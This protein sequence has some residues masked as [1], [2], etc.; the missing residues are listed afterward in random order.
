MIRGFRVHEGRQVA[1][2]GVPAMVDG[3]WRV[4]L[5]CAAVGFAAFAHP[6]SAGSITAS[7]TAD[8]FT[9][10]QG[11]SATLKLTLTDTPLTGGSYTGY[12]YIT[13]YGGTLNP[14]GGQATVAVSGNASSTTA[15][16]SQTVTYLLP[17]GDTASFSGS[18]TSV[19]WYYY[20]QQVGVTPIYGYYWNGSASV[21]GILYY[22]P[23]YQ[24]VSGSV[25]SSVG[26]TASVGVHVWDLAPSITNLTWTPSVLAGQS[27]GFSTTATDVGLSQGETLTIAYD[28]S[29]GSNYADLVRSG[30]TTLGGTYQFDTAGDH[31]INVR[32]TDN[33]G[34]ATYGYFYVQTIPEPSTLCSTGLAALAGLGL[35]WRR[36]KGM[37]A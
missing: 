28:F 30:V 13:S 22:E 35:A 8:P 4:G 29:G 33:Y 16:F 21:Y 10:N 15:S 3:A 17:G 12:G 20:Q 23:V 19:D 14:G 9:F 26:V 24:P 11:Q 1:R 34:G 2:V 37:A 7:L 31:R 36:R 25:T 32:I 6:A 5:A 27:F 18:V